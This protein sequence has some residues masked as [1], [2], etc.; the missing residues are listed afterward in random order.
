MNDMVP[1]GEDQALFPAAPI[2]FGFERL[3][4]SSEMPVD[5]RTVMS[6][7]D[8][9]LGQFGDPLHLF[10]KHSQPGWAGRQTGNDLQGVEIR[11]KMTT[12]PLALRRISSNDSAS[13]LSKLGPFVIPRSSPSS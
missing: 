7:V 3:E 12:S 11:D 2:K 4:N 8:G 6:G 1:R 13:K 9:T 5:R 10:A